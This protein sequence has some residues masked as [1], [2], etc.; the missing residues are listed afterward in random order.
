[1]AADIKGGNGILQKVFDTI[2]Q[3]LRV[4]VETLVA[5][6]DLTLDR[7]KTAQAY[8]YAYLNAVATT[9]LKLA[10]GLL[11]GI[12]V[13]QVSVGGTITVYDN[14]AGNGAIIAVIS[15]TVAGP[16][17]FD[18]ESKVGLT[19]VVA[20]VDANFKATLTYI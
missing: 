11:H 1:M 10:P 18:A 16:H 20:G 15:P 3:G 9:V 6:E 13:T 4:V 2:A 12:D 8:E 17:L 19:V 7:I 14:T 5:G